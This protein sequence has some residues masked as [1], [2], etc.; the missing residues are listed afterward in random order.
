MLGFVFEAQMSGHNTSFIYTIGKNDLRNAEDYCITTSCK[1]RPCA[2][3]FVAFSSMRFV[4]KNSALLNQVS[5]KRDP[6]TKSRGISL[7]YF[8]NII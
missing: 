8:F 2:V 7:Y 5:T 4:V 6:A 3:S 1:N